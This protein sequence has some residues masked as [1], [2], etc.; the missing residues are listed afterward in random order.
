MRSHCR[1]SGTVSALRWRV[2]CTTERVSWATKPCFTRV[3]VL[4]IT[5]VSG[6]VQVGSLYDS[7]ELEDEMDE[8]MLQGLWDHL[9]A[10]EQGPFHTVA[11]PQRSALLCSALLQQMQALDLDIDLNIAPSGS[12]LPV[13]ATSSLGH[14]V[15]SRGHSIASEV[16]S[17]S[18]PRSAA[19]SAHSL[20]H[21]AEA[22][23]STPTALAQ[24]EASGSL[25]QQAA[26]FTIT[27]ATHA[28]TS[29]TPQQQQQQQ[30]QAQPYTVTAA[31]QAMASG[32]PQQQQQQQAQPFTLTAAQ[33]R[34]VASGTQQRGVQQSAATGGAHAH[35]GASAAWS[36]LR[37]SLLRPARDTP[38]LMHSSMP[39]PHTRPHAGGAGPDLACTSEQQHPSNS[40]AHA[41][42]VRFDSCALREAAAAPRLD[43]CV[44]T[45]SA[46]F[47]A[48]AAIG[49][50]LTDESAPEGHAD[51]SSLSPASATSAP[52]GAVPPSEQTHSPQGLNSQHSTQPGTSSGVWFPEN[53][54]AEA[55]T[56]S[57]AAPAAGHST[58]SESAHLRR[59]REGSCQRSISLTS[60]SVQPYQAKNDPVNDSN[61]GR[62]LRTS[63]SSGPRVHRP[64]RSHRSEPLVPLHSRVDTGSALGGSRGRRAAQAAG[65]GGASSV[66]SATQEP[67]L[68]TLAAHAHEC[69][70]RAPSTGTVPLKEALCLVCCSSQSC[71]CMTV[72]VQV[73]SQSG[74]PC[75]RL[76]FHNLRKR[77]AT[78]VLEIST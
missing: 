46:T 43:G 39:A 56:S 1:A 59:L 75:I 45:D 22:S 49:A 76:R 52:H 77:T 36:F 41:P 16:S 28:V 27:A 23:Q 65:S 11:E 2:G 40:R 37:A 50:L 17:P 20:T 73:H 18:A 48:A 53:S 54:A 34:A 60:P 70:G 13:F 6:S 71:Y 74:D 31:T 14:S 33:A 35:R 10:E 62:G 68:A 64:A 8:K 66:V 9:C 38:E 4:Q 3:S 26:P 51:S 15:L 21:C 58:A 5:S 42:G 69:F 30:Q 67:R 44:S 29:G 72:P 12:S 57:D 63:I 24:G 78:M 25:L 19:A 47:H 61:Y 7:T 55:H 32:I